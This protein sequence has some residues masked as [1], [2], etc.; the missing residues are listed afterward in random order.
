MDASWRSALFCEKT[1]ERREDAR[2]SRF[3][4]SEINR[5]VNSQAFEPM[6][7]SMHSLL[8]EGMPQWMGVPEAGRET[9]LSVWTIYRKINRGELRA[10]RP[11]HRWLVSS[12]DVRRLMRLTS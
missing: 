12:E 3:V 2:R 4:I 5:K 7:L 8:N 10:I 9:R 11:G 6:L 1:A